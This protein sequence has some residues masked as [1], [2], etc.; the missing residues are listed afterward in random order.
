VASNGTWRTIVLGRS[1]GGP[2]GA[3][4]GIDRRS[5]RGRFAIRRPLGACQ[6]ASE[7]RQSSE[8]AAHIASL[9][10]GPPDVCGE[11]VG[12][13][14]Y[15]RHRGDRASDPQLLHGDLEAELGPSVVQAADRGMEPIRR[16]A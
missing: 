9:G 1:T 6:E 4:S 11:S 10:H 8:A 15:V 12:F 16:V 13:D 14:P 3:R 2:T 5:D 7:E